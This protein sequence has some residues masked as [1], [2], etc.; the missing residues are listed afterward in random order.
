[1]TAIHRTQ[2]LFDQAKDG[3]AEDAFAFPLRRLLLYL[4]G[5]YTF[6]GNTHEAAQVQQ[7][8][9]ALY[10]DRTGTGPALL[11]LEQAIGL[12]QDRS[13]TEACE[14]AQ[15]TSR[16]ARS[17]AWGIRERPER[18]AAHQVRI[19]VLGTSTT[20]TAPPPDGRAHRGPPN[21]RRGSSRRRHLRPHPRRLRCHRRLYRQ[22]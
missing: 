11:Q 15:A 7:Q 20:G 21:C 4:S 17:R 9:L 18:P 2:A 10:P 13:P 3:D 19:T 12:A 6:L 5:A 8:T 16:R 14:P 1:M 22:Q